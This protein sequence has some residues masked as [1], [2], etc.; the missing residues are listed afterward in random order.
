MLATGILPQKIFT[1]RQCKNIVLIVLVARFQ[2]KAYYKRYQYTFHCGFSTEPQ[3][4]IVL[5][6][7][8]NVYI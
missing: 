7:F 6:I 5:R 4:F 3:I 1:R 8:S 2:K